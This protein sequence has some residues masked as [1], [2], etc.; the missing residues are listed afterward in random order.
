MPEKQP[1]HG[2][3]SQYVYSERPLSRRADV[4]ADHA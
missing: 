1:E 2:G 4:A 3:Q